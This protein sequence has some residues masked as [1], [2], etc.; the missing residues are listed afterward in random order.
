MSFS[1]WSLKIGDE[2]VSGLFVLVDGEF[3][4]LEPAS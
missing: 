3:V 4:Q 1:I 2:T